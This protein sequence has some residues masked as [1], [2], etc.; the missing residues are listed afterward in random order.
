MRA[1]QAK[2]EFLIEHLKMERL[3]SDMHV[4]RL[5]ILYNSFPSTEALCTAIYKSLTLET[6]QQGAS[7][8]GYLTKKARNSNSW[9]YR[10][11]VLRYYVMGASVWCLSP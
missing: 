3:R 8:V 10:F 5:R 1:R 9:K 4:E 2:M 11:F 7:K 6:I